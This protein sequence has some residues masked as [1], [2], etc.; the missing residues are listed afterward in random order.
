MK[1]F[2]S[3]FA[4]AATAA[5]AAPSVAVAVEVEGDWSS[6]GTGM[7][8]AIDDSIYDVI[9]GPDGNLYVTGCIED[10]AGIPEADIVAMWDGTSW[11]ALGGNG[12]GDGYFQEGCGYSITWDSTGNLI[13]GG[14]WL[15]DSDDEMDQALFSWDGS[16]W[17]N[18]AQN[19]FVSGD[20]IRDVEVDSSG[21]IYFGGPFY[22]LDSNDEIDYLARMSGGVVS[23]VGVSEDPQPI[24]NHV[25]A[26][27][28]DSLD[29]VYVGG[30]FSNAGGVAEADAVA[31][32]N[33]TSWA[34]LDSN[35]S[36]DGYFLSNSGGDVVTDLILA[37]DTLFVAS[38]YFETPVDGTQGVGVYEYDGVD[39]EPSFDPTWLDDM[40][41]SLDYAPDTNSLLIAGWF[42]SFNDD[43]R[44][45][46]LVTFDLDT[47]SVD[48]FG[49]IGSI[50]AD[51]WGSGFTVSYLGDGDIAYGGSFDNLEGIPA[52]DS[53]GIWD[54]SSDSWTPVGPVMSGAFVD[55][56]LDVIVGPDGSI[57]ATGC[58]EDAS[59]DPTA[60]L[61]AMW[62][63]EAWVGLGDN[64]DGNGHFAESI[65]GCGQALAW[66]PDGN[67][68][69]AG[70]Q[71][72]TDGATENQSL[73][74]WNGTTWTNLAPDMITDGGG[75]RDVVVNDDGT[76]YIVGPATDM[77]G[78]EDIDYIAYWD[79]AVFPVGDNGSGGPS[80]NSH[81][82]NLE[83]DSAGNI[84]VSGKFTNAGGVAAADLVARWDGSAWTSLGS[85]GS[86]DGYF[87][88]MGGN[89]QIHALQWIDGTLYVGVNGVII[90]DYT[91]VYGVF[92]YA[93][94][95]F[96]AVLDPD[97]FGDDIRDFAF[98]AET[99]RLLV[100][101]YFNDLDTDPLADGLVGI[102]LDDSSIHTYGGALY[103]GDSE[104]DG[105]DRNGDSN[106]VTF[107]GDGDILYA[108][109]FSNLN[110][111]EYGDNFGFWNGPDFVDEGGELAATGVDGSAISL[112]AIAGAAAVSGG[113]AVRRR[114]I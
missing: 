1:N 31:M 72:R 61:I 106:A 3:I 33:G 68:V 84:Y 7:N 101:G 105:A 2:L 4:I 75:L 30:K 38:N 57:Y 109:R 113:L 54:A 112:F 104:N 21:V 99:N 36:G 108:G 52:A 16:E 110:A 39:F 24:N 111:D 13:L 90:P 74:L 25:M 14:S 63:G 114:R 60:D 15:R 95:T 86:G 76:M 82:L 49:N 107:V 44:A 43:A 9:E 87:E 51:P 45:S 103:E 56:V 48:Y 18:L 22:N 19:M 6:Y 11:N 64:G 47:D 26:I 28:I 94:D 85:D 67:L 91:D 66:T 10:A 8:S 80:L 50:A 58:F 55:D 23:K 102:D 93:D 29:N 97:L 62:D 83:S 92:A 69:L 34:G 17:T 100:A 71:L 32:W 89:S 88:P 78:N 59:N 40:I 79:D 41:R 77:G 27:E 12:L 35:G 65:D 70:R 81:A 53:L 20:G 37:N 46:G 98:D 96:S 42:D 73:Y 5:I